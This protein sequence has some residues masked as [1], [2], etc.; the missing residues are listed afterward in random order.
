MELFLMMTA[1]MLLMQA[2]E[3]IDW[4]KELKDEG[5]TEVTEIDMANLMNK[6]SPDAASFFPSLPP[7][8]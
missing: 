6:W 8:S 7:Q 1:R 4:L 5:K 3:V 2:P